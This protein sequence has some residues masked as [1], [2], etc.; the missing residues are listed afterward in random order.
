MGYFKLQIGC[1][2]I[3]L[4]LL[5]IY[6]KDMRSTDLKCSHLY[7]ILLAISPWAILF[8]GATAW[9]VNHPEIVPEVV[10]LLLHGLFF[11]AMDLTV[12]IS[13][14]YMWNISV[15]L[16]KKK[17]ALAAILSPSILSIAIILIFLKDIYYVDGTETRYAM[18]ISVI[19]GYSSLVVHFGM[20]LALITIKYKTIEKRKRTSILMCVLFSLCVLVYQIIQPEALLTSIFPV[21]LVLGLYINIEDPAK[22]RLEQYNIEVVS[23]FA[24]LVENRDDSTGN[25][26]RRTRGYVEILLNEMRKT[27]AYRPF[28][29]QDYI[30]NVMNAAPMHDIGKIAIPDSILQKPGKL[31]DDEF[32]LMKTHTIKGGNI[33]MDTFRN[34]DEPD[35]IKIAYETARCHHE[36][37]NGNGYPDGLAGEEIPLHARIMAIADVFDAVSEKRCYREAMPLDRCF[38]IIAQG[39]GTDFDPQLAALFLSAKDKVIQQYH[40][41]IHE[42]A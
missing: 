29:T 25:H 42:V 19:A 1:L 38:A 3:L 36:K 11:I 32:S 4:Y 31:T 39:A 10:N 16:P 12:I 26:V 33:I 30:A 18:G 7:D 34:L 41:Q 22:R 28:I 21:M 40:H 20:I 37:W 14:L 17:G 23:G 5:W 35:Y 15:G 24:T 27:A 13:M 6:W 9:T 8:D 2:L